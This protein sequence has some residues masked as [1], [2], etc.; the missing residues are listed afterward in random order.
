MALSASMVSRVFIFAFF[1]SSFT[2]AQQ[3]FS[4]FDVRKYG[5]VGDGRQDNTQAFLR[6]WED[7]CRFKG[8][9]RFY[10]AAGIYMLGS[11]NFIGP[12]FGRLEFQLKGVLRAPSWSGHSDSW[13]TFRYIDKLVM[14]GG[15]TGALDGQG[16]YAWQLNDCHKNA[17]CPAIPTT[18]RLEFISYSRVHHIRSINSKNSH[19]V[20][21]GCD[22][23]NISNI[24]LSAPYNSPNTDGIKIGSSTAIRITNSIIGTG[25]DCVA[26]LPGSK[27][28]LVSNV[29]CAPGHG[30]SVGSL[31]RSQKEEN[32]TG[33]TVQNC[34]VSNSTNGIRIKT[35]ESPYSS[36]AS[37]FIFQDIFMKDVEN[38]II[39]D[40]MYCPYPP[41]N[42]QSPSHVQV[43]DVLYKNIWGTSSTEV[44]VSLSC[45]SA[46]PC[47]NVVLKDIN[48]NFQ[49][50]GGPA[51]S[52]CSFVNGLSYG[53]QRPPSCL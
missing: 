15:A 7:A 36:V 53:Q 43:K 11:V 34:T 26:V 47:E 5:A 8:K 14:R 25:D 48:L 10:V 23:V 33:F 35:W 13:I 39:I 45:S 41:C 49:G 28:I 21:F 24:R 44:A 18:L 30:F 40:Q 51:K 27:D 29:T 31:G 1:F 52:Q 16:E 50:S 42:K 37:G 2:A 9:A 6:A 3:K 38:P 22:N 17:N 4:I 12:C 19:I 32:V 20:L 46:L